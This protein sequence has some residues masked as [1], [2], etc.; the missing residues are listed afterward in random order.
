MLSI[1]PITRERQPDHPERETGRRG[2]AC[3]RQ[4]L[5][6]GVRGIYKENAGRGEINRKSVSAC[7]CFPLYIAFFI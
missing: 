7:S 1:M 4:Q 6:A 3:S 2:D 5:F